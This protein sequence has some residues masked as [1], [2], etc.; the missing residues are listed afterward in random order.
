MIGESPCIIYYIIFTIHLGFSICGKC[1]RL[2]FYDC[3]DIFIVNIMKIRNNCLWKKLCGQKVWFIL[4]SFYQ[5][6][7]LV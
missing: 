5:I 7:Y 6:C 4:C 2:A 3:V 1:I